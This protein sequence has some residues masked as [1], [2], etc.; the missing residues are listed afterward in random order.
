MVR[1]SVNK[2]DF[3]R[4]CADVIGAAHQFTPWAYDRPDR[5]N[6]RDAGNG[7]FPGFGI[8][9]LFSPNLVQV[10]LRRPVAFRATFRSTDEALT[11]LRELCRK[12]EGFHEGD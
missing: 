2:E 5:W 9:R 8:I 7:R 6:N 3:Y 1:E 12:P 4:A 11:A 10:S